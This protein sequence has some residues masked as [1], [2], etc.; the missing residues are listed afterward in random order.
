[1]ILDDERNERSEPLISRDDAS[2]AV[3]VVLTDEEHA[4][5]E[6]TARVVAG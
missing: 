6:Q 2:T 5:A 4:I 3:L 1:M